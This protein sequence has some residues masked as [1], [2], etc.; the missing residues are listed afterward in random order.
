MLNKEDS[1]ARFRR[2]ASLVKTAGLSERDLLRKSLDVFNHDTCIGGEGVMY[3]QAA[4][5]SG[6]W[7][8]TSLALR[9][10]AFP[11]WPMALYTAYTVLVVVA[12]RA[13]FGEAIDDPKNA[14]PFLGLQT[15]VS[16]VG[17]ALFFLQTFRTNSAYQRW[18]EGRLQ[19]GALTSRLTSIATDVSCA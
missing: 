8:V 9:G 17:V 12:L 5:E 19:W 2:S 15:A 13:F 14:R 3:I 4:K 16:L 18:W 6:Y 11:K 1:V 10:R 7:F